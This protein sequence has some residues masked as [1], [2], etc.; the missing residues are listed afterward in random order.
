MKLIALM[1]QKG[2]VGKTTCAINIGAGLS[3]LRQKVCLIDLDPQAHLTHSLGIASHTLE[4]SVYEM[5]T[6][7]ATLAQALFTR[8]DLKIIPAKIELAGAEIELSS[9]AGREFLLREALEKLDGFDYVLMDCP[10]S[11]G[12]LTLNALTTAK[13]IYIPLQTEFL[14][15]QGLSKLTQTVEVV[16]KRL[17]KELAIT[18][19]IATRFDQRKN[20]SKEIIAKIK[21]HFDHAKIFKTV[22]RDNVALAEAPSFGQ[23]IFEYKPDSNGAQDYLKLC[24]EILKRS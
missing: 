4:H 19:I 7:K 11:L 17:N 14:A 15:L 5:L 16:Q 24:K 23:T 6:A 13:E 9:I 18:G 2:G 10:P 20:L 22:I 1:N 12:L 21:E 8:G 3:K